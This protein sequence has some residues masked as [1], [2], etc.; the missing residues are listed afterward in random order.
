VSARRIVEFTAGGIDV[1]RIGCIAK[2]GLRSGFALF[3]KGAIAEAGRSA[4][5]LLGRCFPA[6]AKADTTAARAK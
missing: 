5:I 3:R 4:D 6:P 1:A 2:L